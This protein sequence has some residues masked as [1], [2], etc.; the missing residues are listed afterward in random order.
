MD[1]A[2]VV[3]TF[4]IRLTSVSDYAQSVLAKAATT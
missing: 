4:R 3:E 1:M 2:S